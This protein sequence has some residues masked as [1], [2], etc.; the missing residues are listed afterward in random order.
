MLRGQWKGGNSTRTRGSAMFF[1]W[2]F[3][4]AAGFFFAQAA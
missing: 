4:L 1:P 3:V 2:V